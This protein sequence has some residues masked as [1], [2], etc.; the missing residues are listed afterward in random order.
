MKY[1]AP[2]KLSENMHETPEG[3]LL[4][5]DVPIAR[6]GWQLYADGEIPLQADSE[7]KINVYR[8]PK[9]VFNLQT[10]ASFE[11]KPFTIEHPKDFVDPMNWKDL[12]KGVLQNIRRGLD[13]DEDGEESLLADVLVTDVFAIQLVKAGLREVSCGYEAIYEQTG[14]GKGIQTQIVGNHLALVKAGRAGPG[15]AIHDHKSKRE[16]SHRMSKLAEKVKQLF[17]KAT[18]DAVSATEEFEKKSKDASPDDKMEEKDKAKDDQGQVEKKADGSTS[19]DA[20]ASM[21]KDLGEKVA[22]LVK[23][24][25]D[26]MNQ[27]DKSKDEDVAPGI[28]DR[29]Q[30]IE[31]CVAK[32]M[33]MASLQ[34][35]D[36]DKEDG[37]KADP[38]VVGDDDEEEDDPSV[39]GDTKSR[40]EILAPGI[41]V[42]KDV[43]SKAIKAAYSTTDGKVVI[44][45]L[46]GG[47]G[48]T[49]DSEERISNLFIAASEIL[50][51]KRGTGLEGTKNSRSFDSEMKISSDAMTGEK[52]NQINKQFYSQK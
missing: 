12:A 52:L 8:D 23:A 1:Y 9:H 17:Q 11:G 42:T 48:L 10:I 47:K 30:K 35:G 26:D 36:E 49:L 2:T 27:M 45:S 32:L 51:V 39:T 22:G 34:M 21:V 33:E 20:L 31:G 41:V 37:N 25:D 18:N 7:G 4:C 24:N 28:E 29:L 50:K 19:Y 44:D 14:D 46:T 38:M 13:K 3:F 5:L 15:Y 6:T 16:G 43:K 40:A